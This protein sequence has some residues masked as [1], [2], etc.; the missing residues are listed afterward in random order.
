MGIH[1]LLTPDNC[2]IILID[3]QLQM[4]FSVASI[5]HQRLIHNTL[6]LAKTAK[7]FD[8]P[9][10]LTNIEKESFSGLIWPQLLEIFPLLPPLNR[11]S[12][13]PWEDKNFV[14]KIKQIGRQKLVMAAPWEAYLTP[15]AIQGIKA[16]YNIYAVIDATGDKSALAH[17]LAIQRMI[18]AGVVPVTWLQVLRE[19]QRNSHLE[20]FTILSPK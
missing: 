10:I 19:F 4:T 11:T 7:E 8:V 18:Q 6:G 17:D 13:N 5:D 15:S 12:I 1:S 16:G 2:A 20:R 9:V 14:A 3:H